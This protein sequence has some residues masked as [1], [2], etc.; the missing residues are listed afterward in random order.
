MK[1]TLLNKI[2]KL[3]EPLLD[4]NYRAN[5][6]IDGQDVDLVY[7]YGGDSNCPHRKYYDPNDGHGY[8]C[9]REDDISLEE[10]PETEDDEEFTL[11]MAKL[12]I[13]KVEAIEGKAI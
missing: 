10:L 9:I 3:L 12:I 1:T 11:E 2:L 5:L 7:I 4:K 13:N 6:T 8:T